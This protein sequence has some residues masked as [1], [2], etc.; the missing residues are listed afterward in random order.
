MA[1]PRCSI[2]FRKKRLRE[3]RFHI[4]PHCRIHQIVPV[5]NAISFC[6]TIAKKDHIA[7]ALLEL[8]NNSLR[9]H[10]E[11][12]VKDP[13]LVKLKA[14]TSHLRIEVKDKGGGFDPHKLPYN[15]F[16]T[17]IPENLNTDPF[18]Q[19]RRIHEHKRFGMGLIIAKRIFHRF[20]LQFVDQ[21]GQPR[22]W[23]DPNI[24]GTYI[25]ADFGPYDTDH[26]T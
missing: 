19:Y 12:G 3:L 1:T 15:L 23:G 14:G 20:T 13:I 18:L 21:E 22:P 6:P 17:N 4:L 8:I 26:I 9:A 11:K 5:L 7:Y 24:V 25:L 2:L 10:R 16:D